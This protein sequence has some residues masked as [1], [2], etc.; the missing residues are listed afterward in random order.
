[1]LRVV[2]RREARVAGYCNQGLLSPWLLAITCC[3]NQWVSGFCKQRIPTVTSSPVL[4]A[5]FVE[6]HEVY[7]AG[8][9]ALGRREEYLAKQT[10][11]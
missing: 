2:Y 9:A 10:I 4:H 1:M 8:G 11:E 5:R 3:F 6:G 7:L